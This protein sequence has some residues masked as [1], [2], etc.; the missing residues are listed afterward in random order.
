[1]NIKSTRRNV[2]NDFRISF[3]YVIVHAK[4][5]LLM[6]CQ[7][8]RHQGG[9]LPKWHPQYFIEDKAISKICAVINHQYGYLPHED[10][11]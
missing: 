1:M 8:M 3:R 4:M 10:A 9:F 6:E 7:R 5:T 2:T 11:D